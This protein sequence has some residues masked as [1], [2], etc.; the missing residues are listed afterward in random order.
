[1]EQERVF[2]VLVML[3]L[4][5]RRRHLYDIGKLRKMFRIGDIEELIIQVPKVIKILRDKD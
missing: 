1:M 2:L 4:N 3:I 5:L